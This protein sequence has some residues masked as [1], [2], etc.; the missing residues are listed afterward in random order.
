MIIKLSR[1]LDYNLLKNYTAFISL[2][3]NYK[4]DLIFSTDIQSK[5]DVALLKL[6]KKRKTKKIGLVRSWDNLT[7]KGI[8]RL[9]PDKLI[10]A[11]NILKTEASRYSKIQPDKIS[12]IG[13][14]HY[15]NYLDPPVKSKK[16]FYKEM[17]FSLDKKLVLL[18]PVGNRYIIDNNTDRKI[19]DILSELD[20]NILVRL[21]PGDKVDLDGFKS[22]RAKVVI[23]ETGTLAWPAGKKTS[24]MSRKDDL[25]L[26]ESFYHADVVVTGPSTVCIDV[27]VFDKPII[28][29]NFD[30]KK[31]KYS[32][33]VSRYYDYNHI[34]EITK[35]KGVKL[36]S[37]PEE[38][39]FLVKS[40]LDESSLD[41]DGREA[42]VKEQTYLMDGQATERLF[43]IL[44]TYL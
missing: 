35:T 1:F 39:K 2:V 16:D 36:A 7:C 32:D 41:K 11:S 40:Y 43:K 20:L 27:A 3:D 19:L 14:P 6:A 13:I 34:K 17:G 9:V 4:P 15:D 25:H 29:I 24:E 22:K 18:A 10:V 12:A 30:D 44:Q 38:L 8:I 37:S 5:N 33:S 28:F 31:R 26:V 42:I 23:D 21:P